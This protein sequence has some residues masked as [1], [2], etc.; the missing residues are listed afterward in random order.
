MRLG[1]DHHEHKCSACETVWSH[2][3][4]ELEDKE[5]HKAAHECP[6]CGE[7]QYWI[8]EIESP[9]AP[10]TLNQCCYDNPGLKLGQI[11]PFIQLLEEIFGEELAAVMSNCNSSDLDRCA[12]LYREASQHRCRGSGT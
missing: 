6:K 2:K 10:H 5:E 12:L 7:E 9:C 11:N 1:P 4:S 3:R 8:H